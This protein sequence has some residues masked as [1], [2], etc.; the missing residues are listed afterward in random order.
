MLNNIKTRL[1]ILFAALFLVGLILTVTGV[2]DNNAAEN[3]DMDFNYMAEREF[4]EGMFVKGRVYEIYGEFAVEETYKKTFGI[5]TST[6][7]SSH[8]YVVPMVGTFESDNPM[9]I[10]LEIS[11]IG[12]VEEAEK[13]MDQTW[14]YYDYG[15]EPTVWNEFDIK[16]KV[17][18][19]DG[20]LKDYMYEWFMY[21][22]ESASRAEYD[23]L[24]CP[25]VITYRNTSSS[26]VVFTVIIA[27]IGAIGL[28]IMIMLHIKGNNV[29]KNTYNQYSYENNTVPPYS[30]DAV[31]DMTDRG[32]PPPQ[33]VNQNPDN[34]SVPYNNEGETADSSDAGYAS[35]PSVGGSSTPSL[36]E[37][38][39]EES[40]EKDWWAN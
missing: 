40:E 5:T 22:D 35:M 36:S 30:P 27:A 28:T 7:V 14:N 11:H 33:P 34:S 9:Y 19:L 24:I 1:M 16:G 6:R 23:D 18:K 17:S 10:A 25:Y 20:E 26:A 37:T 8:Y 3:A 31:K 12:M 29:P 38:T 39:T 21:G 4:D 13:L 2:I 32:F 15:I